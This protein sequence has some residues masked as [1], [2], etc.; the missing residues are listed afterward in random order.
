MKVTIK[1]QPVIYNPFRW[2]SNMIGLIIFGGIMFLFI[3]LIIV[4]SI[5]GSSGDKRTEEKEVEGKE[6]VVQQTPSTETVE[7]V[8][9]LSGEIRRRR[10]RRR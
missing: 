7:F 2:I 4:S 10:R 1:R 3:I 9:P 6:V 8:D 5:F